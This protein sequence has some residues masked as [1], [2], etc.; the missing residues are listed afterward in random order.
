[1]EGIKEFLDKIPGVV[2]NINFHDFCL[3]MYDTELNTLDSYGIKY[4]KDKYILLQN[5]FIQYYNGLDEK[6]RLKFIKVINEY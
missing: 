6:N 3:K 1:M 4:I 2:F 5:N